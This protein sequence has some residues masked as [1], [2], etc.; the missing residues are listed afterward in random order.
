MMVKPGYII[1]LIILIGN[2]VMSQSKGTATLSGK[3]VD[4]KT[5]APVEYANIILMDTLTNKMVTGVVSDSNG[6]FK[7]KDIPSGTYF[8]EYSFIGYEKQRTKVFSIGKKRTNFDL[9]EL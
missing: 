9:G 6:F 5:I 8:V 3:V 2:A 4:A 1:L 7:I